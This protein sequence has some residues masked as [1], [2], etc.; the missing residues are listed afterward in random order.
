[1][2][3]TREEYKQLL[4]ECRAGKIKDESEFAKLINMLML[5]VLLDLREIFRDIRSLLKEK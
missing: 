1:M 3:R 5:E 4:K 2:T